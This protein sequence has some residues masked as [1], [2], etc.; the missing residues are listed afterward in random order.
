M[1]LVRPILITDDEL[2]SSSVAETDY[3][4][5]DAGT[6][7][8]AG[9]RVVWTHR[10]FESVV[11]GNVGNDPA[12]GATQW[13][14]AGPT[15][16]W[17]M[18]DPA[19]GKQTSAAAPII[20]TLT[21]GAAIDAIGLLD[22]DA[23]SVRVQIIAGG[24]SVYDETRSE[25]AVF[26]FLDL[27]AGDA[28]TV[29]VT[30]EDGGMATIGKLVIGNAFDLG[31]TETAPTISITD[32]SKRETDD[33][34]VTTVIERAWA[35]RVSL[36]SRIDSADV[37]EVQRRLIEVRAIPALWIGEPGFES[38]TLYGYYKDFSSDLAL[39]AATF[40]SLTIE[41]LPTAETYGTVVDPSPDRPSDLQVVRPSPV[42]SAVLTGTN[43]PETDYPEWAAGTTYALGA[44]VI[45]AATHRIYESASAN[46]VGNDPG[47]GAPEWTDI[48]PTNRWAMFDQATGTATTAA[49]EIVVT[50]DP[51]VAISALAV[52]D[53]DAATVRVQ[54]PGYDRTQATT[55][56]G[57]T[58]KALTFLDLEAEAGASITVTIT[59]AG[60]GTVSVG[61]LL[62]GQT[63]PLG[64]IE[65]SPTVGINDYSRKET[66]EFGNT[67]PVER[68]WAMRM[69]VR[70]LVSTAALEGL[71]RR[72]AALRATPAL[73]IGQEGFDSLTVYGFFRDFTAEVA[74][75]VSTCG[76]TIEGLTTAGKLENSLLTR[77]WADIIE[78]Q[79]AN[80]NAAIDEMSSDGILS[81]GEK[82]AL[83]VSYGQASAQW[84]AVDAKAAELAP[85][86]DALRSAAADAKAALTGYLTGLDPAWNDTETSTPIVAATFQSKWSDFYTAL[87]ALNAAMSVRAAGDGS[88][89][90]P[91]PVSLALARVFAGAV[92]ERT[93]ASG[94]LADAYHAKLPSDAAVVH[95]CNDKLIPVVP[96]ETLFF[97]HTVKVAAGAI[98]DARGG[99]RI[100]TANGTFLSDTDIPGVAVSSADGTDAWVFKTAPITIPYGA[101]F[102][103][104]YSIREGGGGGDMF[105]GEP[106]LSRGEPGA[107]YGA[108]GDAPVGN[109]TG[110]QIIA[111]IAAAS[112]IAAQ[113]KAM[114][115]DIAND[116]KFSSDEKK[117]YINLIN[118]W[119]S[120]VPALVAKGRGLGLAAKAQTLED[121]YNTFKAYLA[122][123][124]YSDLS[125]STVIVRATFL[126]HEN[127]FN[128]ALT[129]LANAMAGMAAL[130]GQNALYNGSFKLGFSG[131]NAGGFSY[132][133]DWR[134]N[135]IQQP[136][137][138]G[139]VFV[140]VSTHPINAGPNEPVVVSAQ[141]TG[142]ATPNAF[143][144]VD[145]EWRNG[146]NGATI[147]FS[148]DTPGQNGVIFRDEAG[149]KV[150]KYQPLI[151]PSSTDGSGFVRGY[152]RVVGISDVPYPSGTRWVEQIKVERG[153]EPTA[154][155]DEATNGAD[156]GN[157]VGRFNSGTY[158]PT[159]WN[160]GI[161][162]LNL[163]GFVLSD[164][165]AGAT[166]TINVGASTYRLDDGR[167]LNYP[168]ASIPGLGYA[169]LYF[170]W[171]NDPDL[172]GGT[173]YGASQLIQ[174][175]LGPGKVY[176]GYFTT[177]ATSGGTGGG[178]GGG[179]DFCVAHGMHVLTER[180]AIVAEQTG[181]EDR[182]RTLGADLRSLDWTSI[183]SNAAHENEC[184][185]IRTRRGAELTLAINT[186]CV[187]E[188]GAWIIAANA[189]M[190]RLPVLHRGEL[191]WDDVVAVEPAG[192][193]AVAAIKCH[194][195]TYAA[196]ADPDLMI[197]THNAVQKP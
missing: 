59:A 120:S 116:S 179:R 182:V 24:L 151:G 166:V 194:N 93:G 108:P 114:A 70:S 74:E 169:A 72:V 161:K 143:L 132:A 119:E 195:A 126:G 28:I 139:G 135:I 17:A 26:T 19:A 137:G 55:V 77:E 125:T 140:M 92:I 7:Y 174:D 63:E 35:K 88:N 97:R 159:N 86:F 152:V 4:A 191:V 163:S 172:N 149:A 110:N 185:T 48:G 6:I 105:V 66:D 2:T 84:S 107:T 122:T 47:A 60:G 10:V 89:M 164:S 190:A 154:F 124:A 197:L 180:G 186:P 147:S 115:D 113:G 134:G 78:G 111:D 69:A 165:A 104:P 37:D 33:F 127:F 76:F 173:S 160:I 112:A 148:S 192:R 29:T 96:G 103:T 123:V 87:F 136:A 83:I 95:W 68:A 53:T 57:A 25:A 73:W 94:R 5:W 129:D 157:A 40:C 82:P 61:T 118:S 85:N 102:I 8:S 67:A 156:V 188:S 36:R 133:A 167:V 79:V 189:W 106:Y 39:G 146:G 62:I 90:I 176:L 193:R 109:S 34:G 44:R 42:T 31:D 51:I 183:Q 144:F 46:N 128:F 71:L 170:V 121:A 155:S 98:G 131:W 64:I 177:R 187:T 101:A 56:G 54:A 52:L 41:G 49:A 43:V 150:R 65:T 20:V 3:A 142:S 1:K 80:L 175:A 162:S 11:A 168:A 91:E 158:L 50:L 12:A 178:G 184:V 13:V 117:R 32:Y 130:R 27:P 58:H 145:I 38:L 153:T 138:T 15:N 75:N 14:D 21:P 99:F 45:R 16:R 18:F 141:F 9:Q 81:A 171:R 196:G 100:H 23:Q 181:P 22:V 30:P